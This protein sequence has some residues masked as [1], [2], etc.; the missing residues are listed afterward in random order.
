MIVMSTDASTNTDRMNIEIYVT[1]D[2]RLSWR[3][4]EDIISQ[5]NVPCYSSIEKPII[6]QHILNER[7]DTIYMIECNNVYNDFKHIKVSVE[8]NI[9]FDIE[10]TYDKFDYICYMKKFSL[11]TK[12]DAWSSFIRSNYMFD[13]IA[14]SYYINNIIE[15]INMSISMS[16]PFCMIIFDDNIFPM[17]I[18]DSLEDNKTLTIIGK[19]NNL[20]K[21]N[22]SDI[23]SVIINSSIYYEIIDF[24]R[25]DRCTWRT[26]FLKYISEHYFSTSIIKLDDY[27]SIQ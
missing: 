2:G 15:S 20:D 23:Y 5:F 25:E 9:S 26:C 13:K 4:K 18:L 27:G 12:V 7:Y 17:S 3:F 6:N 16:K 21:E 10:T 11:D 8:E 24:L 1:D 19:Y 14:N 22:I